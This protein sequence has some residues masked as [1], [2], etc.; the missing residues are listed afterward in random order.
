MNRRLMQESKKL[1]MTT[2]INNIGK[3]IFI[4][5]ISS[6]PLVFCSVSLV[7][8]LPSFDIE[9][10]TYEMLN[11]FYLTQL[12]G[13][14]ILWGISILFFPVMISAYKMYI[15]MSFGKNVNLRDLF[16]NYSSIS[17]CLSSLSLLISL[18]VKS[19]IRFLPCLIL[20]IIA[21]V[22]FTFLWTMVGLEIIVIPM[23]CFSMLAIMYYAVGRT[24][25]VTIYQNI[26]FLNFNNPDFSRRDTYQELKSMYAGNTFGLSRLYLS[27][28]V[29]SI[30]ATVLSSFTACVSMFLF[31]AYYAIAI[32][33]YTTKHH[34]QFLP[35]N[36]NSQEGHYGQ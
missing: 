19:F 12:Y 1:A 26:C 35:N 27:F 5:L 20:I 4:I 8:I 3:V 36:I 31:N 21:S 13:Q 2:I 32:T 14:L 29:L 10:F 30:V 16:E 33:H 6:M 18:V 22:G 9:T 11:E 24:M 34:T 15:E 7:N 28:L 25:L 23:F 17:K